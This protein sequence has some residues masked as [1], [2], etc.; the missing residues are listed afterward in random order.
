MRRRPLEE[1][2]V[3]QQ[4]PM[5][6]VALRQCEQ[7]FQ[8]RRQQHLHVD[9]LAAETGS[10]AIHSVQHILEK[11]GAVLS[12]TAGFELVWGMPSE[13]IDDVL[14]CRREGIVDNRRN[15]RRYERTHRIATILGVVISTL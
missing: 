14:P 2:L 7:I 4:F 5:E 15:H 12:P 9:N 13:Q 10:K 3:G 8:V 11:R 1:E 6:N